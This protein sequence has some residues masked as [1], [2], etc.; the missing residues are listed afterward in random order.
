MYW[1]EKNVS[2]K[3]GIIFGKYKSKVEIYN[4]RDAG[5]CYIVSFSV[6][7]S[8]VE[9]VLNI[10]NNIQEDISLNFYDFFH[11]E[12]SD[13]GA[14]VTMMKTI[15][16]NL[17]YQLGNH[18]WQ[19]NINSIT[20]ERAVR[21]ILKNIEYNKSPA[22]NNFSLNFGESKIIV[23]PCEEIIDYDRLKNIGRKV[24]KKRVYEI[25]D[26]YL[27]IYERTKFFY[28]FMHLFN[29]DNIRKIVYVGHYLLDSKHSDFFK[30]ERIELKDLIDKTIKVKIIKYIR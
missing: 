16:G 21:Y 12:L 28:Q 14:Y 23:D 11:P 10:L 25:N 4:K 27:L 22:Q 18:G 20:F 24:G 26:S 30:V 9:L 6:L 5:S 3:L 17:C 29:R 8:T 19:S 13:P 1:N 7:E 2:S 15:E